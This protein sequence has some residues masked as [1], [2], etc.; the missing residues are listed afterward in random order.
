MFVSA[1]GLLI[2]HHLYVVR[3]ATLL[4]VLAFTTHRA[5]LVPTGMYDALSIVRSIC[6]NHEFQYIYLPGRQIYDVN[7][8]RFAERVSMKPCAVM[9]H[10]RTATSLWISIFM[11]AGPS[12]VTNTTACKYLRTVVWRATQHRWCSSIKLSVNHIAFT[13]IIWLCVNLVLILFHI[14]RIA[15]GITCQ[16]PTSRSEVNIPPIHR[17]I[18]DVRNTTSTTRLSTNPNHDRTCKSTVRLIIHT[19]PSTETT[20][21]FTVWSRGD[22]IGL[23]ISHQVGGRK[24]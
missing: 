8:K 23:T 11:S 1:I 22:L 7:V 24:S 18:N 10:S 9:E 5:S 2:V 3:L 16:A 17:E 14:E 4:L 13:S 6:N 12:K 15:T 19:T 20:S 21:G